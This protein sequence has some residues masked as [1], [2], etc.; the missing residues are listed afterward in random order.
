MLTDPRPRLLILTIG[1]LLATVLAACGSDPTPTQIPATTGTAT[2]AATE[3]R[4]VANLD[5]SLIEDAE[6]GRA[7]SMDASGN[8][9]GM[10]NNLE[11][12]RMLVAFDLRAIPAG[13]TIASARLEMRMSRTSGAEASVTL[14]RVTR[15]WA[16]GTSDARGE[17]GRGAPSTPGD[18]TWIHSVFD[19]TRWDTPGGDYVAAASATA[20]I[21][22]VGDYEWTSAG[23][24]ADVRSWLSDPTTNFGWIAIG[25]ESR[26]Q[27][28]KHFDSRENDDEAL[29]PTL[30][31]VLEP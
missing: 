11:A 1:L 20:N 13:A 19:T 4:I 22:R 25:D 21:G 14:H 31:V 29:R 8:F 7:D 3:V 12:R 17:G 6:G 30:V 28:A 15:E 26:A 16:E 5:A 27:T 24:T 23:L 18:P 10:T 9:V 2:P